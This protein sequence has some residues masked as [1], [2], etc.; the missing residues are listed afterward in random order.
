MLCEYGTEPN[1]EHIYMNNIQSFN[2]PSSPAIEGHAANQTYQDD[3]KKGQQPTKDI[4]TGRGMLSTM[5]AV[6]AI[7]AALHETF[8]RSNVSVKSKLQHHPPGQPP[9]HLTFLKIIV[10]IPPY[11]GKNAVQMPHTRV[12]LG[13]QMPPPQ[14]HFTGTKMTEGLQKR[15]QLSN[16]IFTNIRKTEKH[17]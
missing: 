9:G 8:V 2:K 5:I 1:D 16:K 6:F 12:H 4:G 3:K 15:L 7:S 11:P 14:G 13:D 10:Q 17:C